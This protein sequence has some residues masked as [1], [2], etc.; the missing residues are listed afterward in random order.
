MANYTPITD[1]A[2][3]DSLLTGDPEKIARGSEI[4]D[5]LNA[6][7]DAIAT[8]ANTAS[9]TISNPTFTGTTTMATLTGSTIDCGSY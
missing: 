3:K 9:P 5:E 4:T 6:I 8:K 2:A 7:A 1:F